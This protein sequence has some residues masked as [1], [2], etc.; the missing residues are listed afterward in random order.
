MI[1]C[2]FLSPP[3]TWSSLGPIHFPGS[4][5][6]THPTLPALSIILHCIYSP[7][8]PLFHLTSHTHSVHTHLTTHPPT[9]STHLSILRCTHLPVIHPSTYPTTHPPTH[10]H[11]PIHSNSCLFT[12]PLMSSLTKPLVLPLLKSVWA[13]IKKNISWM[14]AYK[15][16]KLIFTL[17]EAGGQDQGTSRFGVGGGPSHW[18]L[19]GQEGEGA[20]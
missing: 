11:F 2:L 5:S 13:F 4:S 10:R 9:V 7:P 18:V 19:T 8:H 20:F 1:F 12:Q 17:L 15:Q 14:V 6:Y 16:Q 3:A